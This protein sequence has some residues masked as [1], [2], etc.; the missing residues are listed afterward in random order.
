MMNPQR[1][2]YAAIQHISADCFAFTTLNLTV[3]LHSLLLLSLFPS[4]TGNFKHNN[5]GT[6]VSA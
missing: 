1:T 6:G 2:P 4:T 5:P 3:F